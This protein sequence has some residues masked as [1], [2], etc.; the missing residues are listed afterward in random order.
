[1]TVM[2]RGLQEVA[3]VLRGGDILGGVPGGVM[4]EERGVKFRKMRRGERR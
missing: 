4:K 2:T 1:M 3:G